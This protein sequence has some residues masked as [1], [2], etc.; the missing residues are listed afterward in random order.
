MHTPPRRRSQ[1]LAYVALVA[2]MVCGCSLLLAPIASAT[3]AGY[4]WAGGAEAPAVARPHLFGLLANPS[5]KG[6]T[7]KEGVVEETFITDNTP[8]VLLGANLPIRGTSPP[9]G[10]I[11]WSSWG[12]STAVGVAQA[13]FTLFQDPV[14]VQVSLSDPQPCGG[15]QVYT[16]LAVAL[17]PGASPPTEWNFNIAQRGA[18]EPCWPQLG[19][20]QGMATCTV[21]EFGPGAVYFQR[22][23]F[24]HREND[25][26]PFSNKTYSYDVTFSKWGSP[27]AIGDGLMS[28]PT[29]LGG[30]NYKENVCQPYVYPVQYRL[31]GLAWCVGPGVTPGMRYTKARVTAYGNGRQVVGSTFFQIT[32]TFKRYRQLYGRLLSDISRGSQPRYEAVSSLSALPQ[33]AHCMDG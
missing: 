25:Q 10:P 16:N 11:H 13:S 3:T 9:V 20:P 4:Y 5:A 6:Y 29:R 27:T 31:S 14:P 18:V 17:A 28:S 15:A 8:Q 2:L 12:S 24:G 1:A 33:S 7:I 30:C 26:S 23:R 22:N 21:F 19:C 32:P